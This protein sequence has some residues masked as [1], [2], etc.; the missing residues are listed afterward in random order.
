[1][2]VRC[3]GLCA[4]RNP[5][6]VATFGWVSYTPDGAGG[7]ERCGSSNG[8]AAVGADATNNV[9]EYRAAIEA[10]QFHRSAIPPGRDSPPTELIVETDSQLVVRQVQGLYAVRSPRIFPLFHKV[11]ALRKQYERAPFKWIPREMNK[12]ADLESRIAYVKYWRQRDKEP[13]ACR[14]LA[15]AELDEAEKAGGT[16]ADQA[17]TTLI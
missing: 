10:L 12:D 8:V 1:M 6:G 4:P 11:M 2:L 5:G 16:V 15:R 9:G 17:Q 13:P 3:D 14:F 7:W